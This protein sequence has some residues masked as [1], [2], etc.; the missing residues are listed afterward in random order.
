[1][2]SGT[3]TPTLGRAVAMAYVAPGHAEPGTMLDVEIPDLRDPVA[4]V[5][6]IVEATPPSWCMAITSASPTP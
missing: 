3:I 5:P 1:M 6:Q 2:T 4:I